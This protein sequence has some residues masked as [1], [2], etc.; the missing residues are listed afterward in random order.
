MKSDLRKSTASTTKCSMREMENAIRSIYQ[1]VLVPL[2]THHVR[3][4]FESSQN[5]ERDE[6]AQIT[7][8][9]SC[10]FNSM[11]FKFL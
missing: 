9:I 10:L 8:A 3:A 4:D 11:R 6:N 5:D 2:N 1:K 7:E